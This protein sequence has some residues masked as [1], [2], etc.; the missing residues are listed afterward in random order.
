[1]EVE[2]VTVV[3][4]VEVEE[5]TVVDVVEEMAMVTAMEVIVEEH[6]MDGNFVGLV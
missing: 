4:T 3:I 6:Q 5:A 2:E 1:M